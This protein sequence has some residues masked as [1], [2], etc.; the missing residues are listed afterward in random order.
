MADVE[1]ASAGNQQRTLQRGFLVFEGN[2]AMGTFINAGSERRPAFR[3]ETGHRKGR[4]GLARG[5]AG[6]RV[7]SKSWIFFASLPAIAE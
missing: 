4:R 7:S 3:A 5:Y 1:E 6:I 2:P